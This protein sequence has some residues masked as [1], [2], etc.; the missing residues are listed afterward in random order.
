MKYSTAVIGNSS[1]GILEAPSFKIPT[2]NIGD[3]QKGRTQ[4]D[5]ILNCS[6]D[7]NAI[8]QAIDHALSP[9]FQESLLDISNPY[10]RPGTHSTI[11]R[12]LENTDILGITKKTFHDVRFP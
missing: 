9:T 7:A 5:S 3:R 2:I 4:A 11:V 12:L 6:P 1:S 10:D 8:R